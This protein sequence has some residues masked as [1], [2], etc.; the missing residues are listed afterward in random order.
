MSLVVVASATGAPGVTT[1]TIG[2]GAVWR[3]RPVVLEVDPHGAVIPARYGMPIRPGL[4]S[5]TGAVRHGA[6]GEAD[7]LSHAQ[8]L[9]GG[10]PVVVGAET[11]QQATSLLGSYGTRLGEW[12]AASPMTILADVG[13]I[14]MTSPALG[15]IRRADIVTL[16]TSP[17][18]EDIRLG[19]W[20][21]RQFRDRTNAGL[22]LV[23]DKPYGPSI[24]REDLGVDVLGVVADDAKGARALAGLGSEKT[25]RR[26]PLVRSLR[27]I[28]DHLATTLPESDPAPS[29]RSEPDEEL[30]EGRDS[31]GEPQLGENADEEESTTGVE[32]S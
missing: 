12:A 19:A 13:R 9:P 30:P 25:L 2:L 20:W 6:D 27:T 28:A 3:Q 16:L 17:E 10:L 15:L 5:L 21:V 23:G 18:L 8:P 7:V 4:V 26:A 24:I 31:A 32:A 14:S 29:F 11:P 22:L 1:T